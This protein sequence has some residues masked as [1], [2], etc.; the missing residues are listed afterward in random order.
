MQSMLAGGTLGAFWKCFFVALIIAL[1]FFFILG[2]YLPYNLIFTF[3]VFAIIY[4]LMTK[5]VI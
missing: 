4:I 5:I 3:A 2:Q 1:I